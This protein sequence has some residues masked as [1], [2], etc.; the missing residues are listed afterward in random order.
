MLRSILDTLK[1]GDFKTT[2]GMERQGCQTPAMAI[3]EIRVYLLSPY[4]LLTMPRATARTP[5]REQG[6]PIKPR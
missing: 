2:L 3:K 5:V 6:H 1:R 4:P